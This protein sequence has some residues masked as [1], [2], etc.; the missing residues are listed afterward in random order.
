MSGSSIERYTL[1]AEEYNGADMAWVI[2]ATVFCWAIIPGVGFLYSGYTNRQNALAPV[3]TSFMTLAVGSVSWMT[4]GY[5]LTYGE[6]NAFIGDAQYLGHKDVLEVASGTI[7]ALLFSMFQ[8][9]FSVAT[10]AIFMGGAAERARL[11]PLIPL[12]FFWPLLVY[13]PIA[14]WTWTSG[15]WLATLGAYDFAG[16]SPVHV[17]S[18][19]ASMAMSMYLSKPLFRS[20]KSSSRALKVLV[21]HRPHNL[22]QLCLAGILIWNGWLAFDGCSTLALNLRSAVAMTT[23]QMSGSMGAITWSAWEYYKTGKWSIAAVISGAIA[24]LVAITPGCG[25]VGLPAALLFGFVGGSVCF[26]TSKFK[27]T[28]MA[29][30]IGWVDPC[31]VTGAHWAGGV[32]GNLMTGIFAQASIAATDGATEIPGG[33]LDGHFVQLGY[34]LADTVAATAYAFVITYC[35]VALIDCVPGLEMLATDES[36][37]AGIDAADMDE[38]F[39][40]AQWA[41]DKGWPK[42]EGDDLERHSSGSG[43]SPNSEKEGHTSSAVQPV[44]SP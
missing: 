3:W 38:S 11:A 2:V 44:A 24:G 40:E 25:Y 4:F 17:A 8:L 10:I 12:V 7:P 16:G 34:Q 29:K 28:R 37:V 27:F 18:G 13:S 19:A 5:S 31:D 22:M 14:H 33:W 41:S 20:R 1:A 36:I 23:T 21:D 43:Y 15:G 35:L 32:A 42:S 6:G 39:Y 30:K 26:W 9:T